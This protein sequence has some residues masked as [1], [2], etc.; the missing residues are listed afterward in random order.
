MMKLP[1]THGIFQVRSH[2]RW[3]CSF[4]TGLL[5]RRVY[6]RNISKQ[7]VPHFHSRIDITLKSTIFQSVS[8][9]SLIK[10]LLSYLRYERYSVVLGG[11]LGTPDFD[12]SE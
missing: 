3:F 1:V 6:V 11:A 5:D 7:G 12:E 2:P 10:E 4:N 9:R 8:F